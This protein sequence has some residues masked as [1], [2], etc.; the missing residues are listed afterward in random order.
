[1]NFSVSVEPKILEW[2]R[3]S[4]GLSQKDVAGKFKFKDETII[5]AWEQGSKKPTFAQIEKLASFY[6]R[7]LAAF[8]LSKPPHELPLP[9]DFRTELSI[10]HKPFSPGTLLAI[11]KARKFQASAIELNSELGK[12]VTR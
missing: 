7:P 8:L 12:P 1:M 5:N 4:I 2:A 3:L 9:K 11:R 10:K 6:K